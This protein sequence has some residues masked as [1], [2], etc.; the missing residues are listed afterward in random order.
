LTPAITTTTGGGGDYVPVEPGSY[1]IAA[2]AVHAPVQDFP[3]GMRFHEPVGILARRIAAAERWRFERGRKSGCSGGGR[4]AE[5]HDTDL[6][7]GVREGKGGDEQELEHDLR[8]SGPEGFRASR[9][10]IRLDWSGF[11]V[12]SF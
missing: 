10:N 9:R 1:L 11:L 12:P 7:H 6:L 2:F 3:V 4:V 8:P 5:S